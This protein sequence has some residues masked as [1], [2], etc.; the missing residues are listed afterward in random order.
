MLVIFFPSDTW[1]FYS[2]HLES[3]SYQWMESQPIF[4]EPSPSL[5]LKLK[6]ALHPPQIHIPTLRPIHPGFMSWLI[7]YHNC[8]F[9]A[10]LS[11]HKMHAVYSFS[12]QHLSKPLLFQ[13]NECNELIFLLSSIYFFNCKPISQL[14]VALNVEKK[15]NSTSRQIISR[16]VKTSDEISNQLYNFILLQQLWDDSFSWII[17][18]HWAMIIPPLFVMKW[19]PSSSVCL[20]P[21]FS[22]T[23]GLSNRTAGSTVVKKDAQR[24]TEQTVRRN[25]SRTLEHNETMREVAWLI[26]GLDLGHL[27]LCSSPPKPTMSISFTTS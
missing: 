6:V 4:Q 16:F 2:L 21:H 14:P 8:P 17:W 26:R 20:C 25:K 27:V 18:F 12:S 13:G 9:Y 15:L 11:E 7:I 5:V 19:G 24:H 3:L 23:V 10:G 22:P 1:L